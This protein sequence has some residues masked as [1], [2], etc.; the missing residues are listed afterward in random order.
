MVEN[1]AMHNF[2]QK[3]FFP[4]KS[5]SIPSQFT[6]YIILHDISENNLLSVILCN[7]RSCNMNVCLFASFQIVFFDIN[8]WALCTNWVN[9]QQS[10]FSMLIQFANTINMMMV[11]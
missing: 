4:A 3:A 5:F 6:V 2:Q 8:V 10:Q 11:S 9:I 7:S 1:S